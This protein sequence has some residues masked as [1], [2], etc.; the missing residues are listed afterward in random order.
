MLTRKPVIY[1]L[2]AVIPWTT[3]RPQA[4][5]PLLRPPWWP[6]HLARELPALPILQFLRCA[7]IMGT[8]LDW[9]GS[10]TACPRAAGPCSF[11]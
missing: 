10:G 5:A 9:E 8:H 1:A 3:R 2:Y 7:G 11:L 6:A 4:V